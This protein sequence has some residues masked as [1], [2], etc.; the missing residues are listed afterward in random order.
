MGLKDVRIF[1]KR[2]VTVNLLHQD[3]NGHVGVLKKSSNFNFIFSL[4]SSLGTQRRK[5]RPEQNTELDS[6]QR[7]KENPHFQWDMELSTSR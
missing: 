4:C 6:L 3:K 1:E 2:E 7:L 5:L